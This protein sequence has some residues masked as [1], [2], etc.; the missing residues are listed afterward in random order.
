MSKEIAAIKKPW[1]A[2]ILAIIILSTAV[3]I[4]IQRLGMGIDF[5]KFRLSRTRQTFTNISFCLEQWRMESRL[6]AA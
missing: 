5:Q 2:R 6:F 4:N 1:A 3:L